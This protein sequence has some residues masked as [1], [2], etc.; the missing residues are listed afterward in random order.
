MLFIQNIFSFFFFIIFTADA[1]L[2]IETELV[3][4]KK[5]DLIDHYMEFIQSIHLYAFFILG[6]TFL[7]SGYYKAKIAEKRRL[8]R[9]IE[10]LEEDEKEKED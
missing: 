4:L 1:T 7:L 2:E 9:E 10:E 6:L 8:Y 5:K 3:D